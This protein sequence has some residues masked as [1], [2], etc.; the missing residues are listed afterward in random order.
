MV[1][2]GDK[3]RPEPPFLPSLQCNHTAI[4]LPKPQVKRVSQELGHVRVSQDSQG[5]GNESW[6]N[7]SN[8]SIAG[9]QPPLLVHPLP[10]HIHALPCN[11][12]TPG[13]REEQLDCERHRKEE[14]EARVTCI[15]VAH[16]T[17]ASKTVFTLHY[18]PRCP[19]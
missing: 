7:S 6:V 17:Q 11:L 1:L 18:S 15:P 16:M 4:H 13:D 9:S 3:I 5:P 12:P 19:G 2:A 8:R 14:R 10:V